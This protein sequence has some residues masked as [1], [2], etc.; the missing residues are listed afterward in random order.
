MT[1]DGR[2]HR[3]VSPFRITLVLAGRLFLLLAGTTCFA[4]AVRGL[5]EPNHLL[6][7]GVTGTSLLLNRLVGLPVGLGVALL[8]L[9]IFLVG[10]RD[11]GRRFAIFSGMAVLVFWWLVDFLPLAPLT[12]DPLLAGIFGGV[13]SG[14]GTVLNL[15]AG[16]S[17][18]GFDILGVV[19]NRRFGIGVGEALFTLNG[20]LV[21]AAGLTSTPEL[22]MYTLVAIFSA[23]WTVDTLQTRRLRKT[24]LIVTRRGE[25]MRERIVQEMKRGLTVIPGTGGYER[26]DLSVLLCVVPRAEVG[27]M[28]DLIRS[29]DPGS[30]AVVLDAGHISGWFR[31]FSTAETLRRLRTPLPATNAGSD[32]LH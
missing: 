7:G 5:I 4:V 24:F 19:V 11:M 16:G 1:P 17:L 30:F 21:L 18:G 20:T 32:P 13:L 9:P 31:P 10:F 28:E 22:A 6:S 15:R 23:S 12:D 14:L 2:P 8:N 29:V 3:P 26:E 27:E 25:A